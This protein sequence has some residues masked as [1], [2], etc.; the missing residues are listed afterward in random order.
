MARRPASRCIRLEGRTL[1]SGA[2]WARTRDHSE[3]LAV[4]APLAAPATGERP[5]EVDEELTAEERGDACR[6]KGRLLELCV[7]R[8]L[9]PVFEVRPIVTTAR[10]RFEGNANMVL[11]DG[12]EVLSPPV[13]IRS[14]LT[15]IPARDRS[16]SSSR[17]MA[18]TT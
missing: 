5:G 10:A 18:M 12:E 17:S 14:N 13:S 7:L 11:E 4:R 1:A 3:Q 9:V 2:R 15:N 6:Q 16:S 8:R